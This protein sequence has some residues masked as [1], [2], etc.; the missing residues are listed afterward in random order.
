ME[1]NKPWI[2]EDACILMGGV[3]GSNGRQGVQQSNGRQINSLKNFSY[4]SR[5]KVWDFVLNGS[6]NDLSSSICTLNVYQNIVGNYK[7]GWIWWLCLLIRGFPT[8]GEHTMEENWL[9]SLSKAIMKKKTFWMWG[10]LGKHGQGGK[11]FQ[12]GEY[13][14][15]LKSSNDQVKEVSIF[16]V[17]KK[18]WE[19]F[20]L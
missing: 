12:E 15:L 20:H 13:N 7:D 16:R 19:I 1:A 3:Q 11:V 8:W 5:Y 6:N 2:G 14:M 17:A 10:G 18:K 4:M 9:T